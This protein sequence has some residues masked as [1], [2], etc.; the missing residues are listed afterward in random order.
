MN[1]WMKNWGVKREKNYFCKLNKKVA[2]FFFSH[3]YIYIYIYIHIIY[4]ITT[5]T[6]FTCSHIK[7]KF[8]KIYT[9]STFRNYQAT[10]NLLEGTLFAVWKMRHFFSRVSIEINLTAP[11]PLF[12]FICCLR[13]PSPFPPSTTNPL[14]KRVWD[15][16]KEMKEVNDDA[17]AFRHLN[18]KGNK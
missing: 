17:S 6:I 7:K 5:I 11:L 1:F 10:Y 14:L 2:M 8:K 13:T 15:L 4:T 18:I 9:P 3:I 16:L 12:V